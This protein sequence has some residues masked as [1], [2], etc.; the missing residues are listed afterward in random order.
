MKARNKRPQNASTTHGIS[1]I[2]FMILFFD[3]GAKFII[4]QSHSQAHNRNQSEL[5]AEFCV[6]Y[7]N[8]T[9]N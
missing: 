9:I 3:N 2:Y 4:T 5:L 8:F 1:E 7:E 6:M